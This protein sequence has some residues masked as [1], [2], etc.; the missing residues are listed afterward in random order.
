MS[1]PIPVQGQHSYVNISNPLTLI[2]LFVEILRE[3][4]KATTPSSPALLWNWEDD[5]KSTPVFI[6]SGFNLHMEARNARPGI[7]ID[8]DQTVFLRPVLGD[9]DQIPENRRQ[10]IKQYYALVETDMTVDCTSA[11]R[12]ESL[13]LGSVVHCFLQMSARV[14][15]QWFGLRD[16]SPII[17]GKTVPFEKD[18]ALMSTPI[19]FRVG[20][21]ARWATIPIL[22]ILQGIELRLGDK[23]DPETYFREISL[24]R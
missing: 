17:M 23:T 22:P 5:L 7:W 6:E 9:R 21:E 13:M 16:I 19:Q 20:Y 3:R 18:V 8:Q 14:I 2:G 15:M 12:G 4:F 24:Q 1:D 10:D 11:D